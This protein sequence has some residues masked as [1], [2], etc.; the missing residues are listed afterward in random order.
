MRLQSLFEAKE[1][2]P[3]EPAIITAVRE[4]IAKF[5][6]PVSIRV[7]KSRSGTKYELARLKSRRDEEGEIMMQEDRF[8]LFVKRLRT[9]MK[10][11]VE[12]GDMINIERPS[13]YFSDKQEAEKAGKNTEQDLELAFE[14]LDSEDPQDPSSFP[15]IFVLRQAEEPMECTFDLAFTPTHPESKAPAKFANNKGRVNTAYSFTVP[16]AVGKRFVR[17][18][19]GYGKSFEVN[20]PNEAKFKQLLE[21]L[22]KAGAK[23]ENYNYGKMEPSSFM[24][25][26]L[27]GALWS[28]TPYKALKRATPINDP[29]IFILTSEFAEKQDKAR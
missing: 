10:K 24:D 16:E 27:V 5:N 13:R 19:R 2:N 7:S 6:V 3:S 12:A 15:R 21:L 25:Q 20:E 9:L 11:H 4:M 18:A 28:L 1:E 26:R 22:I 17:L 8:P 23:F 29:Q 14:A